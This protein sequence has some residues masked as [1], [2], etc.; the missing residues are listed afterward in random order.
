MVAVILFASQTVILLPLVAYLSR[1]EIRLPR[2]G[3][4]AL[5]KYAGGMFLA[6]AGSKLRL[7]QGRRLSAELTE[8]ECRR[9]KSAL[10]FH[11]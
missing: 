6:K 9:G 7:R 8:G 2:G 11:R 10:S 4:D 5:R 3:R 1:K